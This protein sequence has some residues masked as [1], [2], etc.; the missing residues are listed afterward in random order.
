MSDGTGV[1]VGITV[2]F[3]VLLFGIIGSML[4][5]QNYTTDDPSH[6]SHEHLHE[7]THLGF[8]NDND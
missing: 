7:H 5:Y 8:D 6:K 3:L 4:V 1:L 2:C